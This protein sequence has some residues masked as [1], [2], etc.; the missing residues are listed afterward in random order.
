VRG[1][2]KTLATGALL[3][4]IVG[5]LVFVVASRTHVVTAYLLPGVAIAFVLSPVIPT[6][7]VYWLDPEG[8]PP[9]FLMLAMTCAFL[10]WTLVF[11]GILRWRRARTS[12]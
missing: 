9:A 4:V 5:V 3:A 2:F 12:S 6:K 1:M 8:G 7:V 11:A 10:F